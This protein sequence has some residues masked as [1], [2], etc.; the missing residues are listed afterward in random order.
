MSYPMM[1]CEKCDS[2]SR[3]KTNNLFALHVTAQWAANNRSPTAADTGSN[4]ITGR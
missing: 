2:S 1:S 4:I 3:N